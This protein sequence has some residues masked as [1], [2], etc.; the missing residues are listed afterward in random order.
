[1]ELAVLLF[2]V[3]LHLAAGYG[4]FLAGARILRGPPYHALARYAALGLTALLV[5]VVT[6]VGEFVALL[7][8]I[9]ACSWWHA[10]GSE[11]ACGGL[12]PFHVAF[13]FTCFLPLVS[14]AQAGLWLAGYPRAK[15]AAPKP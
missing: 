3:L 11:A 2:L 8:L 7:F 13:V 9:K 15:P 14:L 6:V 10:E 12:S 4:L 1:M 5:T